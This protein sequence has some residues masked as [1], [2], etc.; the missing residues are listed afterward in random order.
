MCLNQTVLQFRYEIVASAGR[1]RVLGVDR[2][3]KN[4]S[5]LSTCHTFGLLLVH[6]FDKYFVWQWCLEL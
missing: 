1:V 6:G 5:T 3:W 2:L 4:S